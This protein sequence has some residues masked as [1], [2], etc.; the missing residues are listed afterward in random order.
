VIAPARVT[1]R[2]LQDL[3]VEIP[4]DRPFLVDQ[5]PVKAVRLRA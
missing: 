2:R 3:V 1:H 5:Q 4:D